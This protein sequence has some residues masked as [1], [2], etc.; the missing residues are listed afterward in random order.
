MDPISLLMAAQAT[1]AAIRRGCEMLSQGK[2]EIQK[3]KKAVDDAKAIFKEAKG[4]WTFIKGLFNKAPPPAPIQEAQ[5]APVKPTKKSKEQPLSYE[6]YRTQMIND[7]CEQLKSFFEIYR[8]LREHCLVLE[9]KSADDPNI[10]AN[11]IDRVNIELQME[12]M[13]NQIRETM[14]YAP[15]ELKDI[16]SRFL[17]MYGRI[18]EEQEFKRQLERRKRIEEQWRKHLLRNHLLDRALTAGTIVAIVIWLWAMLLSL[19]WLVRTPDG[20]SLQ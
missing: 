10:E 11:S 17:E 4:I 5:P 2:Q 9:E 18:L 15:S 12:N 3:V 13:S 16:Y 1:V 20:L 8:Q 19:G 6:E 7:V 14:V